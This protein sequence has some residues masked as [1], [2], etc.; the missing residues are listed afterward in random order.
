M[1]RY[2]AICHPLYQYAMAGFTRAVKIIIMVWTIS[3]LCALPYAFFTK[4]NYIDRP[5]GSGNNL[6]ESAFCAL[7]D[8]NI[9]PKVKSIVYALSDYEH[10]QAFPLYQLS[11]F[12]FF[13]LPL[14]TLVYLYARMG[15]S[16]QGPTRPARLG[17]SVHG[18]TTT[19]ATSRGTILR[20]LGELQCQYSQ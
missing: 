11:S 10:F 19:L 13:L 7:L 4:I 15:L 16:I 20:M 2:L 9:K 3:F 6:Q 18:R 1:E 8:E 5:L 12:L 17:H 14:V